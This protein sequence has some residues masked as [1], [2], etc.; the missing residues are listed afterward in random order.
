MSISLS[1]RELVAAGLASGVGTVCGCLGSQP[2]ES[3]EDLVASFPSDPTGGAWDTAY[4]GVVPYYTRVFEPLVWTTDEMT[5]RPWLA[6]E[7]EPVD[8][9][10][11]VFSLREDVVCHNGDRLTASDVVWSFEHLFETEGSYVEGWLHLRPENVEAIDEH[12]VEFTNT[13]PFPTFP[14]TIAHNMVAIQ[15]PDSGEGEDVVATG[16][17]RIEEHERGQRLETVPFDDYWGQT[18]EFDRLTFRAIEDDST[19]ALSLESGEIDV[20]FEPPRSQL[21]SLEATDGITVRTIPGTET[22]F[23]GIN[24][25]REPMDDPDVRRALNYAVSQERIVDSVLEGVG[26]PARGPF[27]PTIE[28]AAFESLPRYDRDLERAKSLI[29][30]SAYD[31]EEL[32]L[33]T[34]D[35]L[36]DGRAVAET[37]QGAFS[38]IGVETSIEVIEESS[39]WDAMYAGESHLFLV[40][41]GSHSVAADFRMYDTFHSEGQNNV[42]LYEAE[43]TGLYNLGGEVDDLIEEGYQTRDAGRKSTLY[44]Q[45]QEMLMSQ[46]V[47]VP[48]SYDEYTVAM[49][50][51]LEGLD[52]VAIDRMVDWTG[53]SRGAPSD[54]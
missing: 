36:V 46:A 40:Q 47:V 37:L 32:T 42:Q 13:E 41:L 27:A 35:T 14:G 11:W 28:W 49:D 33:A 31:G 17:L 6:T 18:P 26:S 52:L 25:Y 54:D 15:H 2:D 10:T 9:T 53:V 7:W 38:E 19:R 3:G 43:G 12:T 29:S 5:P 1:R 44:G 34:Y 39:F 23:A 4:G 24:L 51:E 8:E 21:E 50:D 16:P 48:V 22:T 45:A 20:A 30:S